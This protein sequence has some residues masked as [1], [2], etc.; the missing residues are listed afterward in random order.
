MDKLFY[1]NNKIEVSKF[2]INPIL[3]SRDDYSRVIRV[4]EV[5]GL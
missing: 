5:F 3:Q 1:I 2:K 4:E